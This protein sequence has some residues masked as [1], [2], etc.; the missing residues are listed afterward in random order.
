MN[1]SLAPETIA[2]I[3]QHLLDASARFQER[4][5]GATAERQPIHSVYGG[6]QLFRAGGHMRLGS[7]GLASMDQH[8]SDATTFAQAI[9]LSDARQ[10]GLAQTIY[11]RVREKLAR[12]PVE[13]LRVD[14]EDGYGYRANAEEDGHAAF[15]GEQLA[16]GMA[17]GR[18]AAIY[19]RTGQI[20]RARVAAARH[21]HAR[22]RDHDIGRA[23]RRR[24]A[25]TLRRD[26]AEGRD[27]RAGRR[28]GRSAGSAGGS[29]RHRRRGDQDRPDDRD[30]AGDRERPRR[31]R[32]AGADFWRAAAVSPRSPS[33]PTTIPPAAI[34]PPASRPTIT[35]PRISPARRSRPAWPAP[36]SRSATARRPCCRSGR[37][38]LRAIGP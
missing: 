28:A 31:D 16:E 38:A 24:A 14:F 11:T 20:V 23:R 33:G 17:R 12:E 15:V 37:T 22:H 3:T 1:L 2:H 8:A 19:R 13:D 9:G 35:R 30:S 21:P 7:L 26:A 10:D 5:P 25:A 4:Y 18:A 32:G 29:Q 27:P 6:A 34:S 36:A